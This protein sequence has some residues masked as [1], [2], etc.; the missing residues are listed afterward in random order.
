MNQ[1]KAF[2]NYHCCHGP[3]NICTNIMVNSVYM[4]YVNAY[5][6]ALQE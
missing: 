5:D 2:L 4:Q 6:M 3:L 1:S